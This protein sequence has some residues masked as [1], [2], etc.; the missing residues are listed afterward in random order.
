M[1]LTIQNKNNPRIDVVYSTANCVSVGALVTGVILAFAGIT[2]V[3][4]IW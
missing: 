3:L 2:K 4:G 1:S